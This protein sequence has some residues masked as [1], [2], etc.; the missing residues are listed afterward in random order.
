MFSEWPNWLLQQMTRLSM[1]SSYNP[2]SY[3]P[4]RNRENV[5]APR[6]KR[7]L[8]NG[9]FFYTYNKGKLGIKKREHWIRL[10]RDLSTLTMA[11]VGETEEHD[12][13]LYDTI[14]EGEKAVHASGGDKLRQKVGLTDDDKFFLL[15]GHGV[16]GTIDLQASSAKVKETWVRALRKLFHVNELYKAMQTP[17]EGDD[18]MLSTMSA[19]QR[20][21]ATPAKPQQSTTSIVKETKKTLSLAVG[22]EYRLIQPV[23]HAAIISPIS[24]HHPSVPEPWV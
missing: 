3:N 4:L 6:D 12:L 16:E 19:A 5:I 11:V 18:L 17:A 24:R 1:A 7:M 20:A 22:A 15:A 13:N 10:S 9:D 2:A 23:S 8:L 14:M 21:K